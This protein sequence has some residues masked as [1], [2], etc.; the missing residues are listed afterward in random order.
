MSRISR[1]ARA[2]L[3]TVLTVVLVLAV[4]ALAGAS[5]GKGKPGKPGKKDAPSTAQ[6]QYGPSGHQYGKTKVTLCHKGKKTITVGKPAA[7]A[8]L[9]HGDTLGRCP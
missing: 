2:A 5:P 9:R 7:K 8:H 6:Y 3:A 4:A 1:H